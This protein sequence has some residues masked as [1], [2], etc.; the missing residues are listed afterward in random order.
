MLNAEV[1]QILD[2]NYRNA[3]RVMVGV[4]WGLFLVGLGLSGLHDSLRWA[5]LVGLPAAAVPTLLLGLGRNL[6]LARLAVGVAFMVF[7]ALHIHQTL[8][9]TEAHFGIFA[10]LAFLLCYRD[11][12]LLVTAAAVIAVHHL[13]FDYLQQLGFPTYCLTHPGIGTVLVHAAYVIAETGVLCYL[14][15]V[16]QREAVQ[17][18]EL[19]IAVHSMTAEAGVIDLRPDHL[20]ATSESARSLSGIMRMLQRTLAEV[21]D[22]V[23][24]TAEGSGQIVASNAELL[25][26]AD[27]Q[28][29]VIRSTA[30]AMDGLTLTVQKNAEHARQADVLAGSAA[31]VAVRGGTVVGQVVDTMNEIDA[32]SRRIVDI[33]GVIDG[34]AFQTNIL[35]LNAAVE[36]ARAGEQ[37]R[38]FA[39]VASEVRGLAQ[40]AATAARE[41]KQL[42]EASVARVEAGSALAGEAGATME[43]VVAS[44]RRVSDIIAEISAASSA[45]A[46]EI[47]AISQSIT[48]LDDVTRASAR[49]VEQAAGAAIALKERA[50]ELAG[51]VSVFRVDASAATPSA[52]GQVPQRP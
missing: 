24:V 39:V 20:S 51:A 14:A 42:I 15:R 18:A 4:L 47:V 28:G 30:D 19:R 10:L 7:S 3:D 25:R 22:N 49:S 5:L 44:V 41:I 23:Q 8:G 9:R 38:G 1:K 50:E 34:I 31:E 40:R 27:S 6:R 11:W 46:S 36:A 45:Q 37:G 52:V 48:A 35:A 17:A 13:S 21:K 12:L 33:T 32:A 29:T 26:H 2:I 43:E 16:L